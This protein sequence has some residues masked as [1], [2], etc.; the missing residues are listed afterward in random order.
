MA[1]PSPAI[2]TME[3][4][5]MRAWVAG[6]SRELKALSARNF[7]LLVASKPALVLDQRSWVEAAGKRWLCKS[8]RF[9]DISVRRFGPVAL[10]EAQ[11][12]LKATLDG[13][14]WS[15]WMWVTDLW[16]KRRI[17]GWRMVHRTL[18]RLEDSKVSAAVRALQLWR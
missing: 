14:D 17:G 9:G 2:E 4:R 8:Y 6:D 1:D 12:E 5:W 15:G 13:E 18:S 3:N 10:F 11:L 16:R 7:I